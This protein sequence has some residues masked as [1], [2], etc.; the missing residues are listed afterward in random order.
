MRKTLTFIAPL[1]LAAGLLACAPAVQAAGAAPAQSMIAALAAAVGSPAAKVIVG[2]ESRGFR[3]ACNLFLPPA[4]LRHTSY[5]RV[6]WSR[7]RLASASIR[8][9]HIYGQ[10]S[11]HVIARAIAQKY[12]PPATRADGNFAG[13]PRTDV[14]TAPHGQVRVALVRSWPSEDL[15]IRISAHTR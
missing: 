9:P 12:G 2:L 11:W 14:W 8:Y 7:G 15:E 5:L 10:P 3:P 1:A 6:C 13:G 4:R